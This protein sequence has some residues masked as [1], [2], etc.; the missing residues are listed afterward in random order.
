MKILR[1]VLLGIIAVILVAGGGIGITLNSWTNGPLPQHDG[2]LKFAEL[3]DKVEIL[4]DKW[5][6]PHIYASNPHDLFFAQG[7]THAQDRWWQMEFSRHIGAGRIQELTGKSESVMGT[8]IALRT[9]GWYK[10]AKLEVE[11]VYD[12]DTLV[13]LQAFAD[14]VNAYIMSRPAGQ[15]AFEYNLLGVTGVNIKIEPWT[16]VD[17]VVWGKAMAWNLGDDGEELFRSELAEILDEAMLKALDP[18]FDYSTKPSIILPEDLPLSDSTLALPKLQDT[19]SIKGVNDRIAGNIMLNNDP[20]LSKDDGVGS[21]N[22]VV[23]G[24]LS[25]SGAP[26]MAN[27]MHLGLQMPSIW[28]LIGLH[29][30][31]ISDDCP[32]NVTGFQFV[33]SPLVTAGHNDKIS[34][35]FTD[36]TADEIDYF[37]IEINPD[38]ELQYLWDGEWRDM[39]LR[40][41][42]IHFGDSEDTLTIQVRETHLGPIVNDNQLDESGNSLGFNNDDPRILRW[43][44]LI[45][46]QIFT[47]VRKLNVAQDWTE[48]RAALEAWS[49]PSQ[50]VIY[51][52]IEGNIGMQNP[53]IIPIRAKDHS[54]TFPILAN[55][56]EQDWV[57]FVPFDDLPRVFNPARGYVETANQMNVPM[58]YFAQLQEKLAG[59]FGEDSNYVYQNTSAAGYRG[60]RIAELL[61]SL[62]PH[63]ADTFAKIQGDNKDISAEEIMPYLAEIEFEDDKITK[64]REWLLEWDFQMHMDSPQAALYAVFWSELMDV[65][66]NDQ[67]GDTI[68]ANGR[69]NFK[70]ATY[71]LAR[72]PE[73]DWWDEVTTDGI[74][75]RDDILKVAFERAYHRAIELLGDDQSTWKWGTLHTITFVSNPLGLSG[76]QQIEAIVNRG[77]LP[78]SGGSEIVNS[79]SWSTSSEDFTTAH[80]VSERVIYDLSDW[81]KSLA[82]NT[83]GQSGHPFS[84]HYSDMIDSWRFIEYAPL[85]YSRE[86]VESEAV[87]TLIL[88][89]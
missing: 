42:V 26:L 16:P 38:N 84:S 49:S 18:P 10:T 72:E 22:W 45:P 25:K 75:S 54:G 76:I 2:E 19:A 59:E 29:C 1:R 21:N 36:H 77:P 13:I 9:M 70:R 87:S 47:A 35:A 78:L 12:A 5:G 65:L 58:E 53:G 32:Y 30:Q 86:R 43:T 46:S 7:F 63:D 62:A 83:T 64:T 60:Q 15:L 31:P 17:S 4:R 80:G 73:N 14:G 67:L 3:Y 23:D 40:D 79:S 11:T 51:A 66:Y 44:A 41:E 50:N 20:L 56:G 88:T 24:D 71:E 33:P 34:W 28:Y 85:L 27:D 52:D 48:F 61:E 37:L 82:I 74:E 8:D 6:I 81:D 89:P 68:R 57:G 69:G 39:S 55:S